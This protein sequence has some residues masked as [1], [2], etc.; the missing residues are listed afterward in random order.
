MSHSVSTLTPSFAEQGHPTHGQQCEVLLVGPWT[1]QEFASALIEISDLKQAS[2]A[3]D[4]AEAEKLLAD[5][6]VN[7]QLVLLAQSLPGSYR[8]QEVEAL[9]RAA[10]L[11]RIVVVAGTWCEGELRT[12]A[13]LKGV[14]RLYW[15]ELARWWRTATRRVAEGLSPL[16][17][18]PFDSSL[19]GRSIAQIKNLECRLAGTVVVDSPDYMVYETLSE[20]LQPFGTDVCWNH[21][22]PACD[23][24]HNL[25]AG[26]WDGSQLDTNEQE[27]LESFCQQIHKQ[28]GSTIVLLDFPRSEHWQLASRFGVQAV[29]A[30]PYLVDELLVELGC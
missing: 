16:W 29:L 26:I 24:P 11:T 28:C 14:M 8:Q 13:P 4:C 23:F 22:L 9:Q 7:P 6:L 21:R 20:L 30:K 3:A 10:P 17:S 18:A 2:Y 1:D 15:Y 25:I 12:G 5:S 19:A 27:Q